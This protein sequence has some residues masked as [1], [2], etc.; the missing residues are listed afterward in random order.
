MRCVCIRTIVRCRCRCSIR[1]VCQI[2]FFERRTM[3]C[4]FFEI[5][6][7]KWKLCKG[8]GGWTWQIYMCVPN[9]DSSLGG[10]GVPKPV[11]VLVRIVI[12]RAFCLRYRLLV[13]QLSCSNYMINCLVSTALL[14]LV[15]LYP[16]WVLVWVVLWMVLDIF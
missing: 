13:L 4:D 2:I 6:K 8:R 7:R 10:C 9:M 3:G 12:P 14:G 11:C 1:M 16:C 15:L 5:E